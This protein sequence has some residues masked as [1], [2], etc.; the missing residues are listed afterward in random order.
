[1]EAWEQELREE[2]SGL[3]DE[4]VEE[5]VSFLKS[6]D[7]VETMSR[8]GGDPYSRDAIT[9]AKRETKIGLTDGRSG[10]PMSRDDRAASEVS[11]GPLDDLTGRN[12]RVAEERARQ[13][14]RDAMGAIDDL[15]QYVPTHEQLA[16]DPYE[17]YGRSVAAQAQADP[18]NIRAQRLAL[19]QLAGV[20]S[21]RGLTSADREAI[22]QGNDLIAQ[23][24]RGQREASLQDLRERGMAGSGAELAALFGGAQSG[25]QAMAAQSAEIN[26]AAQSRALQ[27]MQASGALAGQARGQ[28]FQERYS[29]GRAADEVNRANTGLRNAYR[30]NQRGAHR[31]VYDIRER[32]AAL[33]TG[34]YNQAAQAHQQRAQQS[35]QQQ[36]QIIGTGIQLAKGFGGGSDDEEDR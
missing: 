31:D 13:A 21:Q 26:R 17:E 28:S 16:G 33:R 3:P 22:S 25:A 20:A 1:M 36:G 10:R 34:Q 23:S 11:L 32:Q 29:R 18:A 8:N 24:L 6:P 7:W 5:L 35:R 4:E 14:R 19:D 30:D 9:V 27:A 2:L 15:E 12:A